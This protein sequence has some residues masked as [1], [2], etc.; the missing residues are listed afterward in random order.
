MEVAQGQKKVAILG[1]GLLGGSLALAL[2]NTQRYSP[3]LW[4]RR[5]QSCDEARSMGIE[6]ATTHLIAAVEGAAIVV[7][8]TPVGAMADLVARIL[9]Q[10]SAGCVVTDMG[11]VKSLPEQAVAPLVREAGFIFIGG[12]PMAGSERAGVLASD[13]ELFQG[14]KVILCP[15][16]PAARGLEALQHLWQ[17]VGGSVCSMAADRH[18]ET[19]AKISHVPHLLAALCAETALNDLDL[20]EFAG[21]GLRDTSRVAAGEPAMWTE[22]VTE[23]SE[24]VLANLREA[25]QTLDSLVNGLEKGDTD[26]LKSF[27]D[28]AKRKRD[29]LSEVQSCS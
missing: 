17:S 12:H 29:H 23:N 22:I 27:L 6:N 13:G 9:P 21:G 4:G 5:E 10:L 25:Q 7:F 1:A 14:A 3:V 8:A 2:Q 11:S 26:A 19:V 16:N 15:E 28:E 18:D 24:A 20:A